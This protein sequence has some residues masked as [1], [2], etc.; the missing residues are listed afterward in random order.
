[1]V[2]K[3]VGDAKLI[4]IRIVNRTTP[5]VELKIEHKTDSQMFKMTKLNRYLTQN[6]TRMT[7][8]GDKLEN[9]FE[10]GWIPTKSKGSSHAE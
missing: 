2:L 4:L 3:V 7:K 5:R 10:L 6:T 8:N 1:M 9:Q